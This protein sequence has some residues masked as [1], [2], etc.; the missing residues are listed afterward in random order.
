MS[1]TTRRPRRFR[2]LSS[3]DSTARS[4]SRTCDFIDR[5]EWFISQEKEPVREVIVD[6][7]AIPT[8]DLTATEQLGDFVARLQERG[9]DFV[10]AQAHLPLR[11]TVATIGGPLEDRWR[12][13]HLADAVAA[14]KNAS[15][16]PSGRGPEDA[17]CS[18]RSAIKLT[19]PC[20]R[21]SRESSKPDVGLH[22]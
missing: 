22:I 14:F 7:R 3:T 11:E 17:D 1:A 9:I 8:I 18:Y 4:S 20:S 21:F 12:F 5:I 13:S 16:S 15:Q 6:A 2:G 19:W 10:V